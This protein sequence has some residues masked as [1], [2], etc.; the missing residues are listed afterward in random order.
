MKLIE[1]QKIQEAARLEAERLMK[2]DHQ[3]RLAEIERNRIKKLQE[4][5]AKKAEAEEELHR[6]D[7]DFEQANLDE[8]VSSDENEEKKDAGI[9]EEKKDEISWGDNNPPVI[10]K[11][12]KPGKRELELCVPSKT[13]QEITTKAKPLFER[14]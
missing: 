6:M 7:L 9:V 1:S 8:C 12:F 4:E 2:E 3:K 5:E 10:F 11:G 14:N 13:I